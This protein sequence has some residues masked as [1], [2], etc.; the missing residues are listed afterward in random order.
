MSGR[1]IFQINLVFRKMTGFGKKIER[2]SDMYLPF[3]YVGYVSKYVQLI[4]IKN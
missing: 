2:F 4:I 3:A 1:A